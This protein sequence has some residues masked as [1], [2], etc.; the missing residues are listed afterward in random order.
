LL[1]VMM[2]LGTPKQKMMSW[3]K[4]TSYLRLILARGL[5]SI[6]LVNLSITRSRWV[7]SPT[8]F[9]KGP[10]RS[11]PHTENSHV[12]GIVWSSWADAWICL[13]KY[14]HPLHDLTICTASLAAIIQ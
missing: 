12:M 1:S 6:H 2:E 8:T 13:T 9:L 7:K 4:F 11:R 10:T 5:T 3:M 14:W